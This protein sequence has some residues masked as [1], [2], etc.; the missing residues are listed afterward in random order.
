MNFQINPEDYLPLTICKECF[1]QLTLFNV[2]KTN[3]LEAQEVLGFIFIDKNPEIIEVEEEVTNPVKSEDNVEIIEC[4]V[5][6]D[7]DEV[8]DD[9]NVEQIEH[10]VEED[11]DADADEDEEEQIKL[12]DVIYEDDADE[13]DADDDD[14]DN[15]VVSP[16]DVEMIDEEY[17]NDDNE[18]GKFR[19]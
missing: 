19:V 5:D 11:P 2:F 18:K 6:E 17:L 3:C 1:S 15:Y 16:E 13:N 8:S 7:E 9:I 14:A 10:K 12:I 4:T